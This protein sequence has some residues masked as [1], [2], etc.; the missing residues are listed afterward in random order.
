M[1]PWIRGVEYPSLG[2]YYLDAKKIWLD[3]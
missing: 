3:K 2:F 1:Q